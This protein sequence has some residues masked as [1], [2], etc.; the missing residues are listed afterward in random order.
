MLI[1][2]TIHYELRPILIAMRESAVQAMI[3]VRQF[4]AYVV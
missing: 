3:P 1:N 4:L 2:D